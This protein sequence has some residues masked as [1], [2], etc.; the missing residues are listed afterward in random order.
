MDLRSKKSRKHSSF[1]TRGSTCVAE[2]RPSSKMANRKLRIKNK[3]LLS[4]L[5]EMDTLETAGYP[6]HVWDMEQYPTPPDV[7]SELLIGLELEEKAIEGKYVIDLGCG[8]GTLAIGCTLLGA[9]RVLAL[10]ID[11][12]CV[13]LTQSNASDLGITSDQL[14]VQKCDVRDIAAGDYERANTVVMNPPFG[15]KE[16]EGIDRIF[17]EKGLA[18]AD[19]VYSLHK[20]STIQYWKKTAA[21]ELNYNVKLLSELQFPIEKLINYHKHNTKDINVHVLKFSH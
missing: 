7:A 21:Q 12:N 8:S 9:D 2:A 11:P 18:M 5:Q 19:N 15:T 3:K 14:V 13:E 10:D 20:A 1:D 16:Q 4:F 6:R 17:V